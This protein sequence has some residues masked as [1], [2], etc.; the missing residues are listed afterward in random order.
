MVAMNR[1]RVAWTGFTGGPGLSTFYFGSSTT[2]MGALKAFLV[3]MCAYVPNSVTMTIPIVGDQIND[4]DGKIVGSWGPGTNGGTAGGAGGAT[5]YSAVSGFAVGWKTSAI[6]AGQRVQGRTFF[7]PATTNA[8]QTDG[9]IQDSVRTAIGTAATT[10]ITAYAGEFKV[11]AR[12]FAGKAA[13]AGPPPKPAIPAR[14]G[15]ACQVITALIP[16]KTMALRS[17]RD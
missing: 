8:Y 14:V 11:F 16:D 1:V 15:Q 10:F 2:D 3:A 7:V 12:P 9:T 6:V 17:R 5:A 13:E 4:T